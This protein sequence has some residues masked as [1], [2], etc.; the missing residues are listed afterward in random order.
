MD[1]FR[2]DK[3]PQREKIVRSF[4]L[5][6][7]S[8]EGFEDEQT[9]Q[10]DSLDVVGR[11][12]RWWDEICSQ[13]GNNPRNKIFE[14]IGYFLIELAKNALEYTA[15][16][17]VK[18]SFE[19]DRVVIVVH[20]Q[21]DGFDDPNDDMFASPDHGLSET[22][23]FADEFTIESNGKRFSKERRKRNLVYVGETDVLS[24]AKITFVK[25]FKNRTPDGVRRVA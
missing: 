10:L 23:R 9:R 17:E 11:F 19:E 2:G 22:K 6:F 12:N 13:T 18:V 1:T 25:H 14:N 7:D 8:Y 16:A 4:S 24:G 3:G 21:G 5:R 15:G 20:D